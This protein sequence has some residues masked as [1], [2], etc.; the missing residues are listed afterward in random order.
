[1]GE[2]E[3]ESVTRTTPALKKLFPTMQ[4]PP[5]ELDGSVALGVKAKK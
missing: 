2:R 5:R 1:V 3:I 4:V